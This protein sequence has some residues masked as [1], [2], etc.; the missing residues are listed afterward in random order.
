[1]DGCG[2]GSMCQMDGCGDRSMYQMDGCGDSSMCQMDGCGDR[3]M[4]QMDGCGDSSMCQMDGCGDSSMCQMDGCGDGLHVSVEEPVCMSDGWLW[5]WFVCQ[6][7]WRRFV[8]PK[9]LE[10]VFMIRWMMAVVG[11]GE[12]V[13]VTWAYVN[14]ANST[15]PTVLTQNLKHTPLDKLRFLLLLWM[16][17][18]STRCLVRTAP[19]QRVGGKKDMTPKLVCIK[20]PRM[21][22]QVSHVNWVI[23]LIAVE[24]LLGSLAFIE[25]WHDDDDDWINNKFGEYCDSGRVLLEWCHTLKIEVSVGC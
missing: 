4:Y 5:R 19:F 14:P 17:V 8:L 21:A 7:V 18:G 10:F 11:W 13:G 9:Q 16:I 12:F 23:Y 25:K 24:K 22:N 1:M 2:D 3:S 6:M 15:L 20:F